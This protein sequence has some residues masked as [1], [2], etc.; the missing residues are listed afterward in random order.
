LILI[1]KVILQSNVFPISTLLSAVENQS[2]LSK[3]GGDIQTFLLDEVTCSEGEKKAKMAY[4]SILSCYVITV[5]QIF[6]AI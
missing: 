6:L 2:I 4:F 5:H 3:Y 1:L